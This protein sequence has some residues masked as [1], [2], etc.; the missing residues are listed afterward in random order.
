MRGHNSTSEN[1]THDAE[2][3]KLSRYSD[4][5]SR[6]G[7][8]QTHALQRKRGQSLR[9]LRAIAPARSACGVLTNPLKA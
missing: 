9:L 7:Q 6:I 3:I 5:F 1:R 8:K 2:E 4:F